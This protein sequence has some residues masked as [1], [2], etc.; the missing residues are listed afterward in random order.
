MS[1]IGHVIV[2]A[3]HPEKN[4]DLKPLAERYMPSE[5]PISIVGMDHAIEALRQADVAINTIPGLAADG[6]AESLRMPCV[7][8]H[9]TLLDV[10]YD[11][12]PTKLMQ[13]GA[14]R[15]ESPLAASRCCCIRPWC[16]SG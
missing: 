12:R 13:H 7:R 5:Q 4:A 9:G 15:E 2:V 16:R 1:A 8:M 11:P 3:R 6:I 10:V 14:N